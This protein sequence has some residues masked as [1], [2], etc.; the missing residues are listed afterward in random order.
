[1]LRR[2]SRMLMVIGISAATLVLLAAAA[3]RLSAA[4]SHVS[5][6]INISLGNNATPTPIGAITIRNTNGEGTPVGIPRYTFG[7]W[8]SSEEPSPGETITIYGR[9]SEYSAPVQGAT[10]VFSFGGNSVSATTDRFGLAS[11]HIYANGPA[12]TPIEIDGAVS[13][14]GQTLTGSTFYSII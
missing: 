3:V 7:M 5:S 9:V 8:S 1:M 11:V 2:T 13:I 6:N 10:V 14:G 12:V 4:F